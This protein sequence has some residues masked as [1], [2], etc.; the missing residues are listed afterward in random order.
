M[1]SFTMTEAKRTRG[2]AGIRDVAHRAGVSAATASRSLRPGSTVPDATRDRVLAA[3][4]DL[5]YHRPRAAQ[6][7]P[8][9]GVLA[10]FPNQWYFAEALAE[11]ER[12]LAA[13]ERRIVLHAVGEEMSR[14]RFFERVLPLGQLDGLVVVSTSFEPAERRA[15]E[16]LQ[17]PVVVIGGHLPGHRTVG[18]DEAAAARSATEHLIGLGHRD[19]GLI[20]FEPADEVGDETTRARTAGFT[21]ALT[22]N[23]LSVNP[24]WVVPA[25]GSRMAG[26][27]RAAE[28]LLSRPR[29]PTALFAMS[30][31][32][33][34]GALQAVRRA[35]LSVPEHLSVVGFDDHEVAA[36]VDLTTVRQSVAEQARAA[37]RLLLDPDAAAQILELPV[38][39]VV[40][41][42]TGPPR[43]L[44]SG[45]H[46]GGSGRAV[47]S[48]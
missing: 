17:I 7:S 2:V 21:A 29:L 18:I 12:S 13:D 37:A 43:E 45:A 24:D 3:A 30:D 48:D 38:R 27:F 22:G 42:T 15:L 40:R 26:G 44:Q 25:V 5:G 6:Q 35:R 34:L 33:A 41:G 10:R 47:G 23:G 32:L 46:R 8:L 39:L 1:N 9:I 31:E 20:A 36:F 16:S 28:I 14:R 11:L 19:I 4:R